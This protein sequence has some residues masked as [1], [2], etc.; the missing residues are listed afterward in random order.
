MFFLC[1]FCKDWMNIIF[2]NTNIMA[3]VSV[4][5]GFGGVLLSFL[6][7]NETCKVRKEVGRQRYIEK[8]AETVSS[9]VNALNTFTFYVTMKMDDGNESQNECVRRVNMFGLI[10]LFS[11]K[12][13]KQYHSVNITMS[14][15]FC[16]QPTLDHAGSAYVPSPIA[17]CLMKLY[18]TSPN[19][20]VIDSSGNGGYVLISDHVGAIVDAIQS[21][22]DVYMNLKS[23][24]TQLY[25]LKV[26]INKWYKKEMGKRSPNFIIVNSKVQ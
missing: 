26:C 13:S 15:H 14:K 1:C 10:D 22:Q 11:D 18:Y 9:L 17:R 8:Q 16:F 3:F 2:D 12:S 4:I 25:W 7:I 23:L 20:T 5:L 19:T 21:S 24:C 6:A